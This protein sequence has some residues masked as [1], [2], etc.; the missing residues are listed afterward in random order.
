M[1]RYGTV[2]DHEFILSIILKEA[3]N[4]HFE[5]DLLL[6]EA[7]RGLELELMSVLS[8]Q[9]RHNGSFA[10]ALIWERNERRIGF[11]V[12]SALEGDTGNELW[13][14]AVAPAYR[15][16]GEGKKMI[17]TVLRQFKEQGVGLMARCTPESEAMY[18]LL[19]ANGF[20][21]DGTLPQGTR[22]LATRW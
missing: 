2:R 19:T 12:M 7:T 10:Y 16:Q 9:R 1:M 22:Q 4:G 15:R 13:L 8:H 17:R 5:R 21:L 14:A 3:A 20:V 18:H 6:P 11:I